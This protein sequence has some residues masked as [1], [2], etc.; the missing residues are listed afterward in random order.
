MGLQIFLIVFFIVLNGIFAASEIALVSANR[1]EIQEDADADGKKAKKAKRVLKLI[2]NPTRFLST[3]QIG[4]TMFGFINGVIAADAF[5]NLISDQIA[6]WT[7]FDTLIIIPV[8]TFIITLILT[9]FQVIFGELVPK[10]IAMK[11]P[12][13]VSYIFIGFLSVIAVIMK[14]FVVL[15]TSSANLIIRLFGINPQD[16]DDTLSEEELILEL[17]ASESKGF[18]D[19]SENEMIQNIFEFD[20]TTV[21]EVMTHR[22]EVS[23]INVNSTRDELVKFVTN[24]KYTRFPVY[25]ET[26]DKIVGTLHVKDLLKYLSDHEDKNEFDIQEILRDPLFVPQ[27]KNTRALFREMK[28][29]KTHIAIVIDE[30]GGTAGII[31]FEDLIEEILGNISDEY[32]EDEEEI[33]TISED[34]Y[35][36]D[37]LIDLDD[38]EDLIHAGL[39][40]EDYDT[41][42]GFIL[43]QLGR[44]PDEDESIVVVYGSYRFEVLSYVDKIIE[45]VL[46]TRIHEDLEIEGENQT[47]AT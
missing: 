9:Y 40:I 43:G 46:V 36:I 14:P 41:L 21:E 6:N 10:R 29:T 11:S 15:L 24:E 5:S 32:D 12:E 19:S 13:R 7:G 31:T 3:I 16:D 2:E 42:S 26:L 30:Y 44:F 35:E 8:V 25:E 38:V 22:T 4:I 18:I 39:P 20:S 27:S 28:L 1:R 17:N 33:Q 23:A 47:D 37:G 34:S 45:S